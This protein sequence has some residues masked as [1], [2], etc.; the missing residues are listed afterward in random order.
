MISPPLSL[1]GLMEVRG[2]GI[3][4]FPFQEKSPLTLCVEICEENIPERL[5]DPSFVEYYGIQIPIL[6]LIKN[7]PLGM[8]KVELK[9]KSLS[10]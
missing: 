2:I 10:N 1:K 7:D 9:I 4:T 3:C 5:P 8:L 6:K